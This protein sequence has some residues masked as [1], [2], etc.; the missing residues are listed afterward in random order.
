MSDLDG[1][2]RLRSLAETLAA[3]WGARASLSTT[4]GRERA[5]LRLFG[6]HG[7]DRTGRP[8][9]GEAVERY[10]A[11]STRRLAAEITLPFAMATVEYELTPQEV[12]LDVAAGAI[13]LALEAELLDRPEQRAAAEAAAMR[14]A[15]SAIERIDANR[16]ARS[17]LISVL[18]EPSRP[19]VGISLTSPAV[20]GARAEVER[21]VDQGADV[22][23][24][25]VPA[26]R[27][28]TD[29]LFDAGALDAAWRPRAGEGPEP[30]PA[31]SQ[32][33]LAELR[34]VV[35][36]GAAERQSYVRMASAAPPLAAPEQAVVAAF[37]RLDIVEIDPFGEIVETSVDPDRALADHGFANLLQRRAGSLVLAA[38]GPLV[39]APDMRRGLPSDP[40]TR[41]GRS[42]ALQTLSVALARGQG[43]GPEHIIVGAFPEWLADERTPA[44]H[45]LA[46]VALRRALFPELRLAFVEP[47]GGTPAGA[48]W[49]FLLA[50]MLPVAGDVALV[51]RRAGGDPAA[52][53]TGTREAADVA[54][55]A[56]AS[57]GPWTLRGPAREEASAAVES[58]VATLHQLADEGWEAILGEPLGGA[59]RLRL[60]ADAVVERSEPFDL[61]HLALERTAG[62]PTAP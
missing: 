3:T 36:Q 30:P 32:R 15:L 29:R 37:E 59:D 24:V 55:Q 23:R 41:A 48:V 2:D 22:I 39:V 52:V 60:G 44:I 19:W 14:M 54:E 18:G 28:L 57:L 45:A 31:G 43:L 46:Q 27:E 1:L 61:F 9:A 25:S 10:V 17:E 21:L 13:D 20:D 40:A 34:E 16:T 49:S 62:Q 12:A 42:L 4:V 38:P 26:G 56:S 5:I 11:G 33:G 58:A 50:A 51:M 35:D 53:I 47:E 8:L 6:V 7:L